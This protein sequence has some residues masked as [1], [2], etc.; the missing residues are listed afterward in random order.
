MKYHLQWYV[1]NAAGGAGTY[2]L[3]L[4][5]ENGRVVAQNDWKAPERCAIVKV[6]SIGLTGIYSTI[7]RN[8]HPGDD[9]SVPTLA[10]TGAD[11]EDQLD[12]EKMLGGKGIIVNS[13]ESITVSSTCTGNGLLNCDIELDTSVPAGNHRLVQVAGAN[14]VA[15]A[16]VAIETGGNFR[17]AAIL[18]PGT[19]YTAKAVYSLSTTQHFALI[20]FEKKGMCRIPG[21]TALLLGHRMYVLPPSAQRMM[22]E[23]GEY[24][25]SQFRW[26]VKATAADA[27][28][29]QRLFV[30]LEAL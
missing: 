18:V 3:G 5:A 1:N 22:T 8:G 10:D 28:N 24:Y 12:L 30:L 26:Y 20:G 6:S 27:A 14:A 7:A 25:Q 16:D 15:V 13:G 21:H 23:T 9:L 17:A 2:N 19:R 4:V 11:F 29:T